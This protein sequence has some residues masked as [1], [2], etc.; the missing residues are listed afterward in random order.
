M[1]KITA[2]MTTNYQDKTVE[3][4]ITIPTEYLFMNSE[5][6]DYFAQMKKVN[7]SRSEILLT[8]AKMVKKIEEG[9]HVLA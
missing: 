7:V 8:M 5:T 1:N 9:L 3:F 2:T 6:S 4:L